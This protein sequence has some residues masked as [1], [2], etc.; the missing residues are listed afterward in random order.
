L[1][2]NPANIAS[3]P[4]LPPMSAVATI[5]IDSE[6]WDHKP[7]ATLQYRQERDKYGSAKTEVRVLGARLGTEIDSVTPK[8]LARCIVR[9]QAWSPFVFNVCPDWK[10]RRRQEGLFSSCQVLGVDYDAGDSVEEIVT[11]AEQLGVRFNILHH[12]FSSTP[13]HPKLRGIIFLES[14]ITVLETAKL[15]ATGLAYSLG[16]DRACVDTARLYFG[17]RPDSIIH[18][19]NDVTTSLDTLDRLAKD[20]EADR[21]VVTRASGVKDHDPDWGTLDDQRSIWA[22]LTPGK[23]EFVKRKILGILREIE[24]FDGTDG[25]SRYECVWK[26]TSRIARMPETVGNVTYDWVLERIANNPYFNDWDKD[27]SAIVRNAIAWSYD[28]VEP[29]V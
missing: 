21:Y 28:H 9:G 15:L 7:S 19:D 6:S 17:S 8:Q 2:T 5:S 16:G 12:S 14:E 11:S 13:E 23:R 20:S 25:T 10:R 26:R 24:S 22:K 27:A 1:P 18:L 3:S 4:L 29:P